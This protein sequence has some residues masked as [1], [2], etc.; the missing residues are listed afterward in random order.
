MNKEEE[1]KQT[2]LKI[3]GTF[4]YQF[5]FQKGVT[6]RKKLSEFNR[7]ELCS[8][9]NDLF[10]SL[11]LLNRKESAILCKKQYIAIINLC[12]KLSKII[13][14][15]AQYMD[16]LKN[17][18]RI[19]GAYDLE[20]FIIYYEWES[21]PEEKFFTSRMEI[22]AGFVYYLNKM[23][24][25]PEFEG[26][27]GNLPS[28]WGKTYLVDLASAFS[29]GYDESGTILA[30]CSNDDVVKGGSRTIK[31]IMQT[32]QYGEVFPHLAYEKGDKTY[33]RKDTEGEWKLKNCKLSASYYARTTESNVVGCRASKWVWIDD[34]YADYK[35]ALNETN[36]QHYFTKF[37]TVWRKRFV[38]EAPIWKFIITGTMWSPKDFIVKIIVW[39]KERY[40]F[41]PHPIFK[42]TQISEDGKFAIIQVPALNM[43]T[44]M[45]N[46]ESLAPTKTLLN[47]RASLDAY[48]WECN[49]Q[50]NP[51]S[52]EAM[53]FDWKNLKLY[54]EPLVNEYGSTYAVID[55][56][57]KSGKDFFSM[58]IFQPYLDNYALIDCIYTQVAT[59]K[60]TEEICQKI[61]EHNIKILVIETNV[62]GGL[63]SVIQKRL[64]E[65]NF[66]NGIQ[67][68]EKYNTVV[69]QTRIELE[70]GNIIDKI[71]YPSQELFAINSDMGKFM[72]AVTMYNIEGSNK[73]DDAC[74]EGNTL[75]AT[76]FGY[77]KI[78][79]IKVGDKVITPVGLKK[80]TACGITGY[81]E[82]INKF[83]LDVTPNHKVYN[84][85]LNKF[86]PIDRFTMFEECDT[87]SLGGIIKWKKKLLNLT[88]KY[89][90]EIQRASIILS[91]QLETKTEKDV[92]NYTLRYG[93]ITIIEKCLK[94]ITYTIKTV[95]SIIITLKIWNVFLL[96]NICQDIT[97]SVGKIL[98]LGK[99]K[100]KFLKKKYEKEQSNGTKAKQVENGTKNTQKFQFLNINL[101]KQKNANGV[102]KSILQKCV[103][104]NIVQVLVGKKQIIFQKQK[105]VSFAEKNFIP[106]DIKQ[107]LVQNNAETNISGKIK[108]VYNLTVEGIGC[109]YANGIL[110]SNCDSLAMMSSEIIAEKSKPLK[111]VV[112]KRPV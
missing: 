27:V 13:E 98:Y 109:Y 12:L 56:T 46:C 68:R 26:I 41:S 105:N 10:N 7:F 30:L 73:H 67:I 92:N 28:G 111:P 37:L 43:E 90:K 50:Q 103:G 44:G 32:P 81:K 108:P 100:E 86:M 91:T 4:D 34:L 69:K 21:K 95:M 99:N 6:K 23:V 31:E 62:D 9:L 76:Q 36:N 82:T 51:V 97:K 93:N 47:E 106:Q 14:H 70:R 110:V 112:I 3:F 53:A 83:G 61:I 89:T 52:P 18:Y 17:A 11:A 55:G 8:M 54:H 64:K 24:T 38:Q 80:V 5:K 42:Y 2:I 39:L 58:P 84:K 48:I 33:Y 20:S 45:S 65:L 107:K 22:L 101:E 19:A 71:Y 75:I 16:F 79:D 78:K 72:Q 25:D 94:A 60:L 40:K 66:D 102:E 49:F 104:Q 35:E 59:S 57:R 1:I 15:K 74:F 63:K 88:E 87:L 77:K 96:G 29:Y 85:I